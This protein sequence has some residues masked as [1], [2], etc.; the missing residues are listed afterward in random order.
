[1]AQAGNDDKDGGFDGGKQDHE[2]RRDYSG[3][4]LRKWEQKEVFFSKRRGGKL[5]KSLLS[6]KTCWRKFTPPK[7]LFKLDA[8]IEEGSSQRLL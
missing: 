3:R 7:I 4:V 6:L 5:A 1:M 2:A 8:M